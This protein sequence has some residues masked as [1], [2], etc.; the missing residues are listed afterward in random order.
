MHTTLFQY[1]VSGSLDIVIPTS[2]NT[3]S[4]FYVH[5]KKFFVYVA[6]RQ[7]P[8]WTERSCCCKMIYL[9]LG[10]L[11][12]WHMFWLIRLD[13]TELW[14]TEK[15]KL[16]NSCYWRLL[17]STSLCYFQSVLRKMLLYDHHLD[18]NCIMIPLLAYISKKVNTLIFYCK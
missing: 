18:L 11:V 10:E 2:K 6:F 17:T 3:F 16:T 14:K 12:H 5:C 9:I 1:S 8:N 4:K 7:I 13:G 15:G